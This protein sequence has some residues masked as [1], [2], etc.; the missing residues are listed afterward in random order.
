MRLR[1]TLV[2]VVFLS[3]LSFAC[4]PPPTMPIIGVTWAPGST[5]AVTNDP[6][7]P[8][9]FGDLQA[10]MS[11]WN[12]QLNS[13]AP[14]SGVSFVDDVGTPSI[15]IVDEFIPPPDPTNPRKIFR[16]ITD[17]TN[18][19]FTNGRLSS[20]KITIN[21]IVTDHTAITEV[22]AHEIGHTIGLADCDMC[23][24]H[25]SVMEVGDAV[26]SVNTSIGTP[27]PTGCDIFS[28]LTIAPDYI[29][30]PPAGGPPGD[31]CLGGSDPSSSFTNP[32]GGG[33]APTC[34]P[35]IVDTE[36]EGF[37][38]T[39]PENGVLFDIRGDGHPIRIAWT[40]AGSHNAFLALDRNNDGIIDSGKE[41]FGNFTQQP[42]SSRPN[43]FLALGEFDKPENGGNND[44]VIDEHDAVYSKLR[45]WIDENHD[46]ASQPNELH[47]L[48]ELG[49]YSLSLNYR[50]SSRSDEFGNQF[51]FKAR[52]NP[53]ERRDGR[54]EASEVG[55][56]AY[57]VFLV[58]R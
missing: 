53:G 11:N 52:V 19:N 40:A 43:G 58:T 45:L 22:I 50:E 13:L 23:G 27:G 49:V 10:A 3:S 38:L 21:N 32:S 5:V 30:P 41:L 31:P 46:G 14:C 24:L 12:S 18:A 29:C 26:P 2:C 36:G 39:S 48:P 25:A 56:W 7:H 20:I 55:R 28:V 6:I 15:H 44:G 54:D 57:D 17:F 4:V 8:V 9:P 1:P 51:R 35:I 47:T 42:A 37:Q 33:P 16:G 34:S